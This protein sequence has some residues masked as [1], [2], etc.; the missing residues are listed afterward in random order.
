MPEPIVVFAYHN[1]GVRCLK[2]LASRL[3]ACDWQV[4]L[5]VTHPDDP[6]E[7][8]WFGSV[9]ATAAFYGWPVQTIADPAQ[10]DDLLTRIAALAPRHIFSFYYRFMLPESILSQAVRGA[11]NMHGSLL[12][13]YRGRAPVNWAVLRGETETGA[14]LHR[15]TARAD[16]GAIV[17]RR[18]VPILPDDTAREVFDKVTLA[19]E[20]TLLDALPA[21]AAD[22]VIDLPND[23]AAGFYCGSR[24]REDGRIDFAQPARV[25]HN[26]I[27]AV[28]PPEYPGAFFEIDGETVVVEQARHW[29]AAPDAPA[30]PGPAIIHGRMALIGG[31]GAALEVLRTSYRNQ[32]ISGAQL[33]QR[34][35]HA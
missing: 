34:I 20:Q 23:L 29:A 31:D 12:P 15:M 11:F 1:V 10:H 7:N 8:I 28:A 14:T 6:A 32:S 9:A 17:A 3:E 18:A 25:I 4:A 33:A 22:T 2:A 13:K 21:I 35:R 30:A 27:R 24:T 26:L 5:V 19:A 16:A